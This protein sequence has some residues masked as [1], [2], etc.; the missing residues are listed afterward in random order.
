MKSGAGVNCNVSFFKDAAFR[1]M[2][3]H[4]GDMFAKLILSEEMDFCY[5]H[6][7]FRH[8]FH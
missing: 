1:I 2:L 8:D 5:A 3:L 4:P 6:R 7:A